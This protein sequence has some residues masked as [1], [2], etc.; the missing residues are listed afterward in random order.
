MSKEWYMSLG[1]IWIR[2]NIAGVQ[3]SGESSY[4][5][6]LLLVERAVGLILIS[7]VILLIS[8]L[9]WFSKSKGGTRPCVSLSSSLTWVPSRV[10]I[11]R[12]P[13]TAREEGLKCTRNCSFHICSCSFSHSVM[14]WIFVSS[15]VHILKS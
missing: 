15:S 2:V 4:N 5:L 1:Y 14:G 7:H 11:T 9:V 6:W 12:V 13:R 10:V 8:K 3:S